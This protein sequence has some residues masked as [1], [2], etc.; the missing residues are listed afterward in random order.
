VI[1]GGHHVAIGDIVLARTA[2]RFSSRLLDGGKLVEIVEAGFADVYGSGSGDD[3]G[4]GA[5]GPFGPGAIVDRDVS[6]AQPG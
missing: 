2:K 1:L 5:A 3:R 4:V 6:A